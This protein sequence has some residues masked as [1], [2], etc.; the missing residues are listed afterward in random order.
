MQIKPGMIGGIVLILDSYGE[1]CGFSGPL[2]AA[3]QKLDIGVVLRQLGHQ[4][5][6]WSCGYH[7]LHYIV[8]LSGTDADADLSSMIL[9]AMHNDFVGGVQVILNNRTATRAAAVDTFLQ[10]TT[11]DA[12]RGVRLGDTLWCPRWIANQGK[13]TLLWLQARIT[14]M[15]GSGMDRLATMK[16]QQA[17]REHTNIVPVRH[18]RADNPK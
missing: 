2:C 11:T 13:D 15:S 12:A 9:P 4:T 5:D 8:L 10:S 7:A 14:S 6:G 1:G 3:L 17:D 18:L 16:W